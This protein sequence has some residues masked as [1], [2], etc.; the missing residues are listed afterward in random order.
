MAT[1]NIIR[2]DEAH[3]TLKSAV[4]EAYLTT[5][6]AINRLEDDIDFRGGPITADFRDFRYSFGLLF[7]LTRNEPGLGQHKELIAKIER[8]QHNTF[9]KPIKL[10]NNIKKI[11]EGIKLARDWNSALRSKDVIK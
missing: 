9:G 2:H 1:E 5:I 11:K 7:D 4:D 10:K 6:L 3:K 8:W